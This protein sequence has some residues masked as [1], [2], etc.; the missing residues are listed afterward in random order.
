MKN[1]QGTIMLA[2]D[3]YMRETTENSGF[4]VLDL[5]LYPFSDSGKLMEAPF[6]F[7]AGWV[8]SSRKVFTALSKTT[9]L[10]WTYAFL[11]GYVFGKYTLHEDS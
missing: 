10:L 6:P 9:W 7:L 3:F 11:S 1:D 2:L 8:H 5:I 4:F